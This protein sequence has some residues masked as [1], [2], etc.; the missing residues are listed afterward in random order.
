LKPNKSGTGQRLYRKRD[1][2]VAVEIKRLVYGEGYTLSGARQ[3][4]GQQRRA[5]SATPATTA[6]Q[7]VAKTG[8]ARND[9][10]ATVISR[11]RAELREIVGILASPVNAKAKALA[12]PQVHSIRR[13]TRPAPIGNGSGSLFES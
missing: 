12:M 5:D 4:L 2:E 8:P 9:K 10:L 6:K 7:S 11:A 13:K 3:V 1:V